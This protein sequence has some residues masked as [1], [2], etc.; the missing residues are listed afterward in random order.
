MSRRKKHAGHENHERW[1]VSYADFITLLFAFFVVM[2][3]SSQ[4][5]KDKAQRVSES[6]RRALEENQVASALAG[7]LGGTAHKKGSGNAQMRGPGGSERS[8]DQPAGNREVELAASVAALESQ[9]KVEIEAG[10]L[11]VNLEP[12][13]LVVSLRQAAFFPSGEDVIEPGTFP[14]LEKIAAAVQPLPNRIRLEGHTDSDPIHNHRF[15]SNWELSTARGVALLVLF[16]ERYRI[17]SGRFSVAG[18]AENVPAAPNENE[19][20]KARNRRVDVVILNE[21]GLRSEPQPRAG[22]PAPES[23]PHGGA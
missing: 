22:A 17:P 9:L 15:R 8:E 14:V 3:A 5:N 2:F 6:V 19:E 18:Y 4:A 20:G 21:F 11:E 7:I 16:T 1:L 23:G 10:L 12:R 13:G